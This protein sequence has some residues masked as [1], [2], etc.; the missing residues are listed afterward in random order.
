MWAV[1]AARLL[2]PLELGGQRVAALLQG[3]NHAL[4]ISGALSVGD[5]GDGE[6]Q[7]IRPVAA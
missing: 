2:R 3:R 7:T 4:A 6:P 1:A 5:C